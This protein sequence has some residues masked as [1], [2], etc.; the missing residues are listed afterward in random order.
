MELVH[1]EKTDFWGLRIRKVQYSDTGVYECQVNTDPKMNFAM[2]LTVTGKVSFK[3][4]TYFFNVFQYHNYNLEYLS[5]TGRIFKS[6]YYIYFTDI[7]I[8]IYLKLF[9]VLKNIRIRKN[10]CNIVCIFFYLVIFTAI[11][12][13]IRYHVNVNKYYVNV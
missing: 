6:D 4:N 12:W 1:S 9:S 5:F 7:H 8:C 2:K 11:F 13:K 10:K 3:Q